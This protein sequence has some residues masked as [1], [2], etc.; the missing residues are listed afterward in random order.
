[1]KT[2]L[3]TLLLSTLSLSAFSSND[4]CLVVVDEQ[5]CAEINWTE[6]PYVDAYSSNVVTLKDLRTNELVDLGA[7][8]SFKTWMIM[9][10]H[11]HGG[12]DVDTAQVS[13]GSYENTGVYYFSGM[14]GIWQFRLVYRGQEYVLSETTI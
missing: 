14:D 12:S 5:F 13:V 10:M 1:M 8:I 3:L 7:S 9:D 2:I 6:G 4:E 11:Q